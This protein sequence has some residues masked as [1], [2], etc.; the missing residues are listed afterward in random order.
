M[1]STDVSLNYNLKEEVVLDVSLKDKN[2]PTFEMKKS[3]NC[4]GRFWQDWTSQLPLGVSIFFSM[5]GFGIGVWTQNYYILSGSGCIAILNGGACVRITQLVPRRDTETLLKQAN[6]VITDQ[7]SLVEKLQNQQE[8]FERIQ[9]QFEQNVYNSQD[10]QEERRE[11]N[12]ILSQSLKNMEQKLEEKEKMN[13][14]MKSYSFGIE[15]DL[16]IAKKYLKSPL[17]KSFLEN[18]IFADVKNKDLYL[19]SMTLTKIEKYE[20]QICRKFKENSEERE[21]L[22]SLMFM[23]KSTVYYAALSIQLQKDTEMLNTQILDLRSISEEMKTS[24]EERE[25]IVVKTE[26]KI[27]ETVKQLEQETDKISVTNEL[28]GELQDLNENIKKI[29]DLSGG[30]FQQQELNI[31]ENNNSKEEESD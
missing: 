13:N 25:T 22:L 28:I 15:K 26:Q 19:L 9:N 4:F 17:D 1:E 27:K 29:F 20:R 3:P 8:S 16:Q 24:M 23:Y 10:I 11:A 2:K 18:Q 14:Y 12:L 31:N 21:S 5:I 30:K 6:Q 7:E